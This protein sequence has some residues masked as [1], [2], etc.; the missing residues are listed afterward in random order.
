VL[1]EQREGAE[2]LAA[3][4]QVDQPAVLIRSAQPMGLMAGVE[5][6]L[7]AAMEGRRARAE[8]GFPWCLTLGPRL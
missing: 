6:S 1:A 7:G 4:A 5:D 3:L 2:P 8:R